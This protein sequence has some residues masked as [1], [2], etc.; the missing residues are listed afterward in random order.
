MIL[1]IQNAEQRKEVAWALVCN[2]YGVVEYTRPS[3]TYPISD[4]DYA[5]KI[6]CEPDQGF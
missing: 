5:I 1:W 6:V 3:K 2:G 4:L